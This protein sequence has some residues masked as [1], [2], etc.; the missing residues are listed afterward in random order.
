MD[1]LQTFTRVVFE[2]AAWN[3]YAQVR[4]MTT[5]AQSM[6]RTANYW[7]FR[8]PWF[9]CGL[10]HQTAADGAVTED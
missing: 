7:S 6:A 8:D 9:W 2:A 5:Q 10:G 3:L 1:E 4:M